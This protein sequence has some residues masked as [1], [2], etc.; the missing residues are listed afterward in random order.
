MMVRKLPRAVERITMV[1]KIQKKA[2]ED[3]LVVFDHRA[4]ALT[5]TGNVCEFDAGV[6][7]RYCRSVLSRD[8]PEGMAYTI[9]GTS[10]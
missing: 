10:I 6:L 4:F 9:C 8:N 5:G 1:D 2:S 7:S 3:G